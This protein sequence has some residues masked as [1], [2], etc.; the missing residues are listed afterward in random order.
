M[1]EAADL[2]CA[3]IELDPN[4][5]RC[6]ARLLRDVPICRKACSWLVDHEAARSRRR[7][8]S[9]DRGRSEP[10]QNNAGGSCVWLRATLAMLAVTIEQA[11]ELADRAL[12]LHPNFAMCWLH[13]AGCRIFAG[14]A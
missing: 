9:R 8:G 3:A 5:R 7:R 6:A 13:A 14:R 12:A 1:S 2:F 10:T 4:Y 11:L